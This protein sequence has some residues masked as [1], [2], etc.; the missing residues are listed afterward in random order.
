MWQSPRDFVDMITE[1]LI[2]AMTAHQNQTR[3]Y[4]G[5]PYIHHPV[6]VASTEHMIAATLLRTHR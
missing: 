3:K 5:E 1:A 4:T 2:Y 6:E